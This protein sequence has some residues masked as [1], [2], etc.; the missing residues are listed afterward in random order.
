MGPSRCSDFV[1]LDTTL[2]IGEIM[3]EEY[4][5]PRYAPP[6]SSGAWWWQ[7]CMAGRPG[8]V[9]RLCVRPAHALDLGL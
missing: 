6:R 3:F 5:E 9:L 7:G 4:R 1:G 8:R 2:R